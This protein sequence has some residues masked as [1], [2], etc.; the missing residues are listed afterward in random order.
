M[1]LPEAISQ[2]KISKWA[3]FLYRFWTSILIIKMA[4][5]S[6]QHFYWINLSVPHPLKTACQRFWGSFKCCEHRFQG[7]KIWPFL[8]SVSL[9]YRWYM[10]LFLWIIWIKRKTNLD[11]GTWWSRKN[12]N[13]I[14][15]TSWRGCYNNSKYVD[16]LKIFRSCY[17]FKPSH[18]S[19]QHACLP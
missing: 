12:N 2:S 4:K 8:I 17:F 10:E 19:W 3:I 6:K 5:L 1:L 9:Y 14:Q 11:F 18:P 15:I 16:N 13:P 7:L